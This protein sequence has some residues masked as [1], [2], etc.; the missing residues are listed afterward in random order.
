MTRRKFLRYFLEVGIVA[1]VVWIAGKIPGWAFFI[2]PPGS[3]PEDEFMKRCIKCGAC[4]AVCPSGALRQR[5]LS[6]PVK[7]IGTPVLIPSRKG[8][9]LAW[10][11]G[12]RRCMEVCPSGALSLA[13]VHNLKLAN[14]VMEQP[15]RCENCM[16]CFQRCPIPGAVLFP[17]PSG[18]DPYRSEQSIP[19][20]LKLKDSPLKPY[21]DNNVCVG[22]GECVG[23]CPQV[24][25]RLAHVDEPVR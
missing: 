20:F 16:A 3:S 5:D 11:T 25:L 19:S 1:S 23:L 10:K 7:A 21:F 22:C 6:T 14:L 8:G 2:R 24:L 9:C 12:C 4:V 17:N 15:E 13:G 18:G